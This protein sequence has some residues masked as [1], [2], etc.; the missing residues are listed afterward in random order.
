MEAEV[1]SLK[2]NVSRRAKSIRVL[3]DSSPDV[4]IVEVKAVSSKKAR[5][6]ATATLSNCLS[7]AALVQLRNCRDVVGRR[8]RNSQPPYLP[9]HLSSPADCLLKRCQKLGCGYIIF[10]PSRHH[11]VVITAQFMIRFVVYS[12]RELGF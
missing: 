7:V 11:S 6:S 8:V 9:T 2:S 3:H 4:Q 10:G 12:W 5:G 1:I